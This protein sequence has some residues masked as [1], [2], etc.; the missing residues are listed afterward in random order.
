MNENTKAFPSLSDVPREAVDWLMAGSERKGSYVFNPRMIIY[1]TKRGVSKSISCYVNEDGSVKW[2][3]MTSRGNVSDGL[4]TE[5]AAIFS[6]DLYKRRMERKRAAKAPITGDHVRVGDIFAG[7]YGYDATLWCFYEVVAVSKSGKS[8]TV[9]E[10]SHQTANGYGFNDWRCRPIPGSYCGDPE[11]HTV[12][13]TKRGDDAEAYIKI[14]SYM[15]A[16]IER[17]PTKWHDAD[18]YY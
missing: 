17:D 4:T 10:L 3:S 11:R 1:R 16:H 14:N 2:R 15:W 5:E 13:Y 12:L 18:N 6:P 7:S 8:V 9:R